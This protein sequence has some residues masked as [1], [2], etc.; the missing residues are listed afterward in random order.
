MA[1]VVAYVWIIKTY[2]I[3]ESQCFNN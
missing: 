3:F 1:S 2:W